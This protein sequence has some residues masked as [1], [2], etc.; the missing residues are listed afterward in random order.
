VRAA[1]NGREIDRAIESWIDQRPDDQVRVGDTEFG[2]E[3]QSKARLD[4]ALH[5]IVA[6]RAEHLAQ[7]DAATVQLFP[8]GLKDLAVGTADIRLFV[9]L[10]RG[11]LVMRNKPVIWRKEND[12]PFLEHWKLMK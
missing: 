2:K 5:P 10:G 11:Y 6:R 1:A 3:P 12:E 9:Q 7:I 8:H 4:H